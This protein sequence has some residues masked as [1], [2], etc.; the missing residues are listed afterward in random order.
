MIIKMQ[1]IRQN[2][3]TSYSYGANVFN[4][5]ADCSHSNCDSESCPVTMLP[6]GRGGTDFRSDWFQVIFLEI[7]LQSTWSQFKTTFICVIMPLMSF[8]QLDAIPHGQR[9]LLFL[10]HIVYP[11]CPV[12]C[13]AHWSHSGICEL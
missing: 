4:Q 5:K 9:C 10:F 11:L 1:L 2:F 6:M 13:L 8:S 3:K 12:Q 7:H